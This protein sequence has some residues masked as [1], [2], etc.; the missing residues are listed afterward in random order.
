VSL[1]CEEF[2][3]KLFKDTFKSKL[4]EGQTLQTLLVAFESSGGEQLYS[5]ALRYLDEDE[6]Q[7]IILREHQIGTVV[8]ALIK[9]Y[10]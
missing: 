3:T 8:V 10:I 9:N 5:K 6:H 7:D 1:I 2:K 4:L